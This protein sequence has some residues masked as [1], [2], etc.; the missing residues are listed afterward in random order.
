MFDFISN[1]LKGETRERINKIQIDKITPNPSQPRQTFDLSAL[2]EL[3]DS[4]AEYGL[5]QPIVVR[6][7]GNEYELVAG[8]RRLRATKLLG[9]T[10]IDAIIISVTDKQSACLALVENIQREN[11]HYFEEA[12]S[13][14]SLM[15]MFSLTQVEFAQSIGKK[16]STIANKIRVSKLSST[17]K[18]LI[19]EHGLTERH[20]RAL[21][22]LD[23]EESQIEILNQVIESNLNVKETELLIKS[24][25]EKKDNQSKSKPLRLGS[26][27]DYRLFVN[28][29]RSAVNQ[30]K[31]AGVN[32]DFKVQEN[33]EEVFV[34][35]AIPKNL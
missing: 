31:V 15:E 12:E 30:L 17:V 8:E 14:V 35:V 13:F 23:D 7:V 10:E 19:V 25:I 20:A 33:E 3:A 4:I 34:T 6:E 32:A 21:L 27:K 18:A 2:Q 16:Q 5:I 1:K 29:M 9:K 28:T 26:I 11:L 24:F 22:T